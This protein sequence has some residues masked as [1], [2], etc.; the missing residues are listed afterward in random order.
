MTAYPTTT[1]T[2]A[3]VRNWRLVARVGRVAGA[4]AS[5]RPMLDRYLRGHPVEELRETEFRFL[6]C[7][8]LP[9]P[10]CQYPVLLRRILLRHHGGHIA[11]SLRRQRR[12]RKIRRLENQDQVTVRRR[13]Q[14]CRLHIAPRTGLGVAHIDRRTRRDVAQQHDCALRIDRRAERPRRAGVIRLDRMPIQRL[15]GG[16]S[17]IVAN[18]L[19]SVRRGNP[20]FRTA[21]GYYLRAPDP[22]PLVLLSP[23]PP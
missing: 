17:G 22:T 18:Q 6:S 14:G 5:V 4:R 21:G 3:A 20:Y 8:V 12:V 23:G 19:P 16:W 7:A 11:R 2:T 10:V 13:R 15:A 9:L 1:I